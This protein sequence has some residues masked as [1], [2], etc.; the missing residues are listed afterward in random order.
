MAHLMSIPKS[1]GQSN[2][3]IS[4]EAAFDPVP[5]AASRT[6]CSGAHLASSTSP[7]FSLKTQ[8]EL[9]TFSRSIIN[10]GLESMQ[11]GDWSMVLD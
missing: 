4:L 7:T 10:P 1:K 2:N 3:P 9:C 8:D 5:E 11:V 6:L